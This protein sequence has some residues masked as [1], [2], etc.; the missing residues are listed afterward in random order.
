[1]EANKLFNNPIYQEDLLQIYNYISLK[2]VSNRSFLVTGATGLIGS[3]IVDSLVYYNR[4]VK[5]EVRVKIYCLSRREEK[6]KERFSYCTPED[7]LIFVAKDISYASFD[8]QIAYDFI[9]HAASCSDPLQYSLHPINTIMSN[10]M[11]MQNILEY[12]KNNIS[13]KVLYLSSQEVYG[14]TVEDNR[15]EDHYGLID[16]N[17]LR[18]SYPESKRI[19]ELLC[20]AYHSEHNVNVTIVRPVYIYGASMTKEDS[21][22][23]AQFINKAV[24]NEDIILKSKGEQKRS[25]CYISDTVCGVFYALFEGESAEA[26]NIGN[27]NSII[28][29]HDLAVLASKCV[30][31]QIIYQV[32]D[33]KEQQGYGQV[34]N[35]IVDESKLK[36]LGWN[37][38]YRIEEGFK[39]TVSI[40]KNQEIC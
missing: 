39:R 13:T 26:Y 19:A 28:S 18:M 33:E 38:I 5:S 30:N 21:K 25:H 36:A 23:V 1:M 7:N 37:P 24:N 6:L 14:K 3:F 32:P 34:M 35:A 29:I 40:L 22:V 2:L 8:N 9:I 12:A 17:Q 10:V 31:K 15:Q 16:F 20:K 11:G 27:T 4:T